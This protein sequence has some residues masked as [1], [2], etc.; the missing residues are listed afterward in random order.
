MGRIISC[1]LHVKGVAQWVWPLCLPIVFQ[2]GAVMSLMAV[3]ITLR[4]FLTN[5]VLSVFLFAS[6]RCLVAIGLCGHRHLHV[7]VLGWIVLK[8]GF[9]GLRLDNARGHAL[10]SRDRIGRWGRIMVGLLQLISCWTLCARWSATVFG[11]FARPAPL[12]LVREQRTR[13]AVCRCM[14][15][16]L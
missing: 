16:P 3:M 7:V 5:L 12:P 14:L 10:N 1:S 15:L 13:R 9:L 8:V 2:W 11:T 4:L 6:R